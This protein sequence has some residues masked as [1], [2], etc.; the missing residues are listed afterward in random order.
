MNTITQYFCFPGGCD[1]KNSSSSQ[2]N[3]H[4]LLVLHCCEIKTLSLCVL[5]VSLCFAV[6][7]L[8]NDILTLSLSWVA[9][10]PTR[11]AKLWASATP[12]NHHFTLRLVSLAGCL[13]KI[14]KKGDYMLL[15][16]TFGWGGK[17]QNV[18]VFAVNVKSKV[19]QHV[20]TQLS[21]MHCWLWSMTVGASL[22]K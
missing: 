17:E 8:Q 9:I 6:T 1:Y 16:V 13:Q 10:T 18:N 15:H 4:C 2:T 22:T 5:T 20:G 12:T 11:E 14:K 7:S 3:T 19:T 21:S